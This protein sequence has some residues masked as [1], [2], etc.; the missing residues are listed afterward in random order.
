[1]FRIVPAVLFGSVGLFYFVFAR[2][3][4][5]LKAASRMREFG[6]RLSAG[7]KR[8]Q[9][10]DGRL[11]G[12]MLMLL[13]GS[14]LL[15]A[16]W[17]LERVFMPVVFTVVGGA[18]VVFARWMSEEHDEIQRRYF[19]WCYRPGNPAVNAFMYRFGGLI[20]LVV[21]LLALLGIIHF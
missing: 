9:I 21:G 6:E 5:D 19:W 3:F 15:R 10:V 1:M 17:F 4:A 12:L 2:R 20:F 13:A 8:L 16:D 7:R 11:S 18:G 14:I